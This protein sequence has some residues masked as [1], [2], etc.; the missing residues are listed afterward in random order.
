MTVKIEIIKKYF[1]SEEVL[2]DAW[3]DPLLIKEWMC[4][5]EG[6]LVPYPKID[7]KIGGKFQFDM[8]VGDSILPHF[9]EYRVMDRATKLQFSWIS[10]NTNNEESI[11][12]LIFKNKGEESC[13]L[14]LIHELLPTEESAQK[15]K[16]GWVRILDELFNYYSK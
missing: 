7:A 2:Y 11:V 5:G 3:L 13:E 6:V 4:P 16:G 1:V 9:G 12:T 15:H 10:G 8:H 14:T